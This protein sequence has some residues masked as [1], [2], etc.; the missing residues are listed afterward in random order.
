MVIAKYNYSYLFPILNIFP[1]FWKVIND[2]LMKKN[3]ILINDVI[4]NKFINVQ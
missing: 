3:T 4:E 2:G 1:N